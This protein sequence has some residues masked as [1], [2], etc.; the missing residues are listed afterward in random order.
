MKIKT[1]QKNNQKDYTKTMSISRN[2]QNGVR[3]AR[4]THPVFFGG[5]SVEFSGGCFFGG[6]S[7]SDFLGG[8][9]FLFF[10]VFFLFFFLF[11]FSFFFEKKNQ[12]KT[13]TKQN[14]KTEKKGVA[15]KKRGHPR[16]RSPGPPV[17]EPP[18]TLHWRNLVPVET[19]LCNMQVCV[20]FWCALFFPRVLLQHFVFLFC[21]YVHLVFLFCFYFHLVFLFCF[22]FRLVFPV[23][24][25]FFFFLSFLKFQ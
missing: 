12:K 7:L 16:P 10:F 17:A 5:Q 15:R 20:V 11:F 2:C 3:L 25:F 24:F 13:K 6:G 19:I 22:Y 1:K 4:P 8:V 9:F 21:F 23:C 14:K 18:L